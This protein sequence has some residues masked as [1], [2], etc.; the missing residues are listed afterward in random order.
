[1]DD[2]KGSDIFVYDWAADSMQRLTFTGATNTDP[3]WAP[4]GAL[5]VAYQSNDGGTTELFVR[6][7][8]TAGGAGRR[9]QISTGGVNMSV[10]SRRTSQLIAA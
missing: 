5:I 3:V 7:S 8:D 2:G 6:P 4:D 1:M 10:W 9:W